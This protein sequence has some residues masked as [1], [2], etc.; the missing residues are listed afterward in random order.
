MKAGWTFS[1]WDKDVASLEGVLPKAEE[2]GDLRL[3]AE[4]Y[5]WVA[6]LRRAQGETEATSPALRRALERSG[7]IGREL[8][9]DSIGAIPLAFAAMGMLFAGEIRQALGVLEGLLPVL[10]RHGDRMG[11]AMV[12]EMLPMGYAR[13]GEFAMA[14]RTGARSNAIARDADVMAILD[15][16]INDAYIDLE[17]GRLDGAA[18]TARE[19]QGEAEDAGALSCAVLSNYLLGM[20]DVVRGDVRSARASL[21]RAGEIARSASLYPW[22]NRVFGTLSW[23]RAMLDDAGPEARAELDRAI[24]MDRQTKDAWDEATLLT[25]RGTLRARS[26]GTREAGLEDFATAAE[27]FT[28]M[29]ARP[30]LV[31]TLRAWGEALDLAGQ[32]GDAGERRAQAD[33][34]AAEMGLEAAA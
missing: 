26:E 13:L 1:P 16:H 4:A 19:C 9:D 6:Y 20:V 8:G 14:E 17:R 30:A 27:L 2:V 11:A 23:T 25:L 29:G 15:A 28:T 34:L 10:Q 5:F 7:E 32:H 22:R 24:E 31:R 12:A 18:D 3:L 33:A 21:E